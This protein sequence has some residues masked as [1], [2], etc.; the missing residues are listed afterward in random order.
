[1]VPHSPVSQPQVHRPCQ[2][3]PRIINDTGPGG[4]II[5]QAHVHLSPHIKGRIICPC[6]DDISQDFHIM[7][8]I[9]GA[10]RNIHIDGAAI[11]CQC[12]VG[13]TG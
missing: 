12:I 13:F 3:F 5:G 1:M 10:V 9:G 2:F 4:F 8:G 6:S 7:G 11:A